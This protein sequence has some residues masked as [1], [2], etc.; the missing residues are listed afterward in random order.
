MM[1]L[2]GIVMGIGAGLLLGLFILC[3]FKRCPQSDCRFC[4]GDWEPLED[5]E[6]VMDENWRAR[7]RGTEGGKD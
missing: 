3:A 7:F 6:D 5:D 4:Y 1:I 2:L